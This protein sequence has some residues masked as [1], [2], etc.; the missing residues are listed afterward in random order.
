MTARSRIGSA[1]LAA[2]AL[3]D[4]VADEGIRTRLLKK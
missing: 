1:G 3:R 2:E 4:L